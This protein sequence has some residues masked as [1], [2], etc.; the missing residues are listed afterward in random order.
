VRCASR[1]AITLGIGVFTLGIGASILGR[2]V[3]CHVA[4]VAQTLLQ[5][6]LA[7][8]ALFFAIAILVNSLMTFHNSS[9]V[10]LPVG[11]F[12]WTVIVTCCA[13]ATTWDSG[14]MVGFLMHWCLKNTMSLICVAC[15]FVMYT[16]KHR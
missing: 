2:C 8:T 9:A 10:L 16:Q 13:A 14:E 15:V 7:F 3:A 1:F 5:L 6:A 4:W 12:P 11:M